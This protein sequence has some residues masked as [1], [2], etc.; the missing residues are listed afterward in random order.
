M[1]GFLNPD[2]SSIPSALCTSEEVLA[3]DST[4][5]PPCDEEPVTL[6][7]AFEKITK[8][9]QQLLPKPMHKKRVRKMPT[10]MPRRSR[11][12][13]SANPCS[14]GPVTS[15][16]QKRVIRSLGFATNNEVIDQKNQDDY[17]KL[18]EGYHH[19]TDSH[20]AALAAIFG[21][22]VEYGAEFRGPGLPAVS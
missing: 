22:Q 7:A 1:V 11:R 10:T 14:P 15:D 13:A 19:L 20:L 17:S 18:F 4:T 16:A 5:Q 9:V 3:P 6:C 2:V 8:P 12:V 21:W